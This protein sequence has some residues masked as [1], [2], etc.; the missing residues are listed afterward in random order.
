VHQLVSAV[1]SRRGKG[2][3]E[4]LSTLNFCL[5]KNCWKNISVGKFQSKNAKFAAE[6]RYFKGIYGHNR[7]FQHL[8]CPLS[9]ICNCLLE[10]C[11]K[12]A[13]SV[14]KLQFPAVLPRLT[15]K[16]TTPLAFLFT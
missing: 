9:E 14:K 8:K 2:D 10:F 13:W 16:N 5:S 15:F 12:S 3:R 7:N 4:Q 11:R 1:A 6:N